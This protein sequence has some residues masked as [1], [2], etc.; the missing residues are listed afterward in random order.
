VVVIPPVRIEPEV[1]LGAGC[2]VGPEV[3]LEAGA[4]I[5]M[6]AVLRRSVVLRS[7]AVD[8]GAVVE[9]TVLG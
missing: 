2:R 8:A 3:Y 6:N 9:E 4:R 5:G 7:A 1:Q